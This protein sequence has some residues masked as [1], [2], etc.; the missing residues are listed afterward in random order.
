LE[1]QRFL[2]LYNEVAPVKYAPMTTEGRVNQQYLFSIPPAL[3]THF[4]AA[5]GLKEEAV[6][7]AARYD[8][9][10]DDDV[11]EAAAILSDPDLTPFERHTLA[12]ARVG[13]GPF[14]ERVR[15]VEP[16]C[17][18]TGLANPAFLVARHLKPWRDCEGAERLDGHNGLLLSPHAGYLLDRGLVT[19]EDSGR[20]VAS[21]HLP[22]A[23][24]RWWQ[25]DLSRKGKRFR[26]EQLPYLEHHRE[27]VFRAEWTPRLEDIGRAPVPTRSE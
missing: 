10:L 4:L 27:H 9:G 1:P 17:R 5:V 13:Q 2:D 26:R 12:R 18:L 7:E 14:K 21:P 11:R 20:V 24:V 6:R 8:P 15:R 25:L 16:T 23:V 3:G 19:F 22:S